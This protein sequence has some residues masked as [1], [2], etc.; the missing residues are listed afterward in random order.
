M[1]GT[2][3]FYVYRYP[4]FSARVGAVFHAYI[5]KPKRSGGAR[6]GPGFRWFDEINFTNADR[7]RWN[8]WEPTLAALCGTPTE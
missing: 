2:P 1:I 8:N 6:T 5:R 3:D 7:S 4:E